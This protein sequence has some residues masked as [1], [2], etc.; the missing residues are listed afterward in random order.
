MKDYYQILGIKP[1]A[2]IAEIKTAYRKLSKKFHPDLNDGDKYFEEMF[3][4]IL[5]AYETLSNENK[6][7][8]YDKKHNPTSAPPYEREVKVEDDINYNQEF[9]SKSNTNSNPNSSAQKPEE[10]PKK[11]KSYSIFGIIIMISITAFF[12]AFN[13]YKQNHR[14]NIYQTESSVTPIQSD[15]LTSENFISKTESI[16]SKKQSNKTALNLLYGKWSGKA[17]QP[18]VNEF[19]DLKLSCNKKKKTFTILY[20]K[21]ECGGNWR[22]SD[23]TYDK[24]Y[25]EE[26]ITF[27]VNNCTNGGKV[28]LEVI[29]DNT[30]KFYYYNPDS[31]TANADG[32]LKRE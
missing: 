31:Y 4:E 9:N 6:R 28:V 1:N 29:D 10:N 18:D 27:G 20:P 25:F 16:S 26:E 23:Y 3:K 2:S 14:A 7:K 22:I 24:I 21:L 17:F 11:K 13:K 12:H 5:G 19:W 8:I 15:T 30:L 32:L